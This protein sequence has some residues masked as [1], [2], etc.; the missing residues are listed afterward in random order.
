[1]G[2]NHYFSLVKRRH[3]Q[4]R[5]ILSLGTDEHIVIANAIKNEEKDCEK[6]F[7]FNGFRKESCGTKQQFELKDPVK[8][9]LD[10]KRK[11]S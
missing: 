7:G 11:F 1:M 4:R 2:P 5:N 6:D 3:R 8:F 10:D 9:R